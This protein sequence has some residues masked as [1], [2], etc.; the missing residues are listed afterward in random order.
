MRIVLIIIHIKIDKKLVF[1]LCVIKMT[2]IYIYIYI[3]MVI[4]SYLTYLHTYLQY[5]TDSGKKLIY[6]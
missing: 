5:S 4:K 2:Y 1:N 6:I 3:E